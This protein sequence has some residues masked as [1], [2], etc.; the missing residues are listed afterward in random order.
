MLNII[1]DIMSI[2]KVES[3]Q[4]EV[5]T[6]ETNIMPKSRYIYTFFKP[7]AEQKGFNFP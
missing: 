5:S 4:M 7:E 1:N 2:S 6:S 3:G